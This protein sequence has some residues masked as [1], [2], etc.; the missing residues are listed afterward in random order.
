MYDI[1]WNFLVALEGERR[2]EPLRPIIF[3]V[4]S[5]GGIVVKEMLRRSSGC[6]GGQIHLHQTFSSTKGIIFF[7]TPHGGADPRGLIHHIAEKLIRAIGVTFNKQVVNTLLPSSERL[8]ELRDEFGP[9]VE[10]QQWV[11]HSFQ[12]QH[13]V[14]ALGGAKVVEDISSYINLPSREVTEHIERNHMEMCRFAEQ[15]DPEYKKLTRALLR[16]VEATCNQKQPCDSVHLSKEHKSK[17]LESLYFDQIDARQ[18]SIREAHAKTC[19]WLLETPEYQSWLNKAE[20]TE[21]HGLLWIKGKPGAGKSTLMKFVTAHARRTMKD[22]IILSFFFNARGENLEKSTVGTYRSLL[23][24]LLNQTSGLE[25][26]L[27][28]IWIPA[29]VPP[30]PTY[31]WSLEAL[32]Y[33]LKQV[34]QGLNHSSIVC[35]IDALDECEEAQ[36]REMISFFEDL[37]RVCVSSGTNFRLCFASRHYPHIN[38]ESGIEL[39]LEGHEGHEHDIR[40]Y[41]SSQLKIGK[42][43]RAE[44][45][46]SKVQEKASGV[47]MWVALVV[48]ILNKEYD[49]GSVH[50]LQRKLQELP[51][52]LHTLFHEILT[53]DN[54][55]IPELVLCLQWVLFAAKPLSPLELYF[56]ILSGTS[57]EDIIPYDPEELCL[58]DIHRFLL[59]RSKGLTEITKSKQARVQFIHESVRDFLLKE[60]GFASICSDLHHDGAAK[61]HEQLKVCCLKFI[62]ISWESENLPGYQVDVGLTEKWPL[63]EHVVQNL[64]HYADLAQGGGINQKEFLRT[65]P[66]AIWSGYMNIFEKPKNRKHHDIGIDDLLYILAE[67]NAANLCSCMDFT[68]DYMKATNHRYRFPLFAALANNSREVT[69]TFLKAISLNTDKP[70]LQELYHGWLRES[71]KVSSGIK[72]GF[73]YSIKESVATHLMEAEEVHILAF[74]IEGGYFLFLHGI[75]GYRVLQIPVDPIRRNEIMFADLLDIAVNRKF[76][77]LMKWTLQKIDEINM[78]RD[79]DS[80]M[81]VIRE[82]TLRNAAEKGNQDTVEKILGCSLIKQL[83]ARDLRSGSV[84]ELLDTSIQVDNGLTV[85]QIFNQ[86]ATYINHNDLVYTCIDRGCYKS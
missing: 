8:K 23:S 46:R 53:H 39:V 55:D 4:H 10:G 82:Y 13:G 9:L 50:A 47:F 76:S 54:H 66:M 64:I 61:S 56:A 20:S 72:R 68:S 79:R 31:H 18:M 49:R 30:S 52:D 29:Q 37:E 63:L 48:S 86:E 36:V 71:P 77:T 84:L 26:R 12:E 6:T 51:K 80:A 34:V 16:V 59:D 65:F 7:G 17:L 69:G 21:Y 60:D 22:T 70:A 35:F 27:D 41:L 42:T 25:I 78:V 11:I 43:K 74:L 24:Q 33:F 3:I 38:V 19:E 62:D 2:A 14:A 75:L 67:R 45:I 44:S 85:K 40:S 28:S 5:L 32:T 57:P 58:E 1:A 15:N 73:V 83:T 81:P